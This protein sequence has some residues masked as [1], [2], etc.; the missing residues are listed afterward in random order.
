MQ[1]ARL[2][3][4][5]PMLLAADPSGR[6]AP[7]DCRRPAGKGEGTRCEEYVPAVPETWASRIEVQECLC[8]PVLSGGRGSHARLA[9]G[10]G[11]W[12]SHTHADNTSA[13]RAWRIRRI[14]ELEARVRKLEAELTACR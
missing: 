10:A 8:S 7:R 9:L 4:L 2:A 3:I 13:W 5:L 1:A 11:Y 12:Q 6:D 14:A